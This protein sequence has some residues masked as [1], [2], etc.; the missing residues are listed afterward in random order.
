MR[1][2]MVLVVFLGLNGVIE[3]FFFATGRNSINK[4]NFLSIF[5]TAFYLAATVFFFTLGFGAAGLFLGNI[6]NMSSRILLCWY[7]EI[8]FHIDF[9]TLL[10]EIRPSLTFSITSILIFILCHKQY[11]YALNIVDHNMIKLALGGILFGVNLL[12]I[13]FEN[14]QILIKQIQKRFLKDKKE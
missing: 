13:I 3:A 6:L 14:R 4:Y 8:R 9:P 7:L 12:P 2:Y 1:T 5:T 11:G 10:K